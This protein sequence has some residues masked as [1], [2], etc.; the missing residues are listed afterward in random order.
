M[1]LFGTETQLSWKKHA[2]VS[3]LQKIS[4]NLE[5]LEIVRK[6]YAKE[7]MM[8]KSG[9]PDIMPDIQKVAWFVIKEKWF[10]NLGRKFVMSLHGKQIK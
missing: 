10:L 1:Q 9:M 3:I 2:T 7:F 4:S 8:H 5:L 6:S